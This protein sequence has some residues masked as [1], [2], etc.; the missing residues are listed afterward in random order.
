LGQI[1][2]DLAAAKEGIFSKDP[3]DLMH[4]VYRRLIKADRR[5]ID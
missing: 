5:V 3:I 2:R 4:Q 1:R